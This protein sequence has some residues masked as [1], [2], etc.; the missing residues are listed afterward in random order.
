L[1]GRSFLGYPNAAGDPLRV[2][3]NDVTRQVK[4]RSHSAIGNY[5]NHRAPTA[6]RYDVATPFQA[7]EM[8]TDAI[9]RQSKMTDDLADRSRASEK[10][11]DDPQS[12]WI[13]ETSNEFRL[14]FVGRIVVSRAGRGRACHGSL[15]IRII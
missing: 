8:V 7:R 5:V 10:I 12:R 1:S 11:T 4:N 14:E 6:L 3:C 13:T 15:Y 2:V 9:L